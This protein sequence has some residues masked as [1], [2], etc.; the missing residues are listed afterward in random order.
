MN[1]T[2]LTQFVNITFWMTIGLVLIL[3]VGCGPSIGGRGPAG[4]NGSDGK[5]CYIQ[6][7][8]LICPDGSEY[9]LPVEGT[10]PDETPINLTNKIVPK[11][12][13]MEVAPGLYVEN[14]RN[15]EIF[16]VYYNA[17]CSDSQGEYCDNV[18]T[19][20]GSSGRIGAG[21]PGSS[22]VCWVND[23]QLSGVKKDNGD[24]TLYIL[25]FI[26]E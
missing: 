1:K 5:G 17:S 13:C 21:E 18:A 7:T 6:G 16:D 25:E 9:D 19:S 12:A 8:K 26:K 3:T 20:Y 15:G 24:I 4:N 22:T 11:H 2:T 23:I 10:D 14:I